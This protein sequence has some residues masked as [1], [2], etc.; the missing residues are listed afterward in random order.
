M[1]DLAQEAPLVLVT[2][3]PWDKRQK[4]AAGSV[5]Q[6]ANF[7]TALHYEKRIARKTGDTFVHV[8]VD[9]KGGALETDFSSQARDH[10]RSRDPGGVRDVAYIGEG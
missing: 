4:R 5:T 2:H 1:I 6:T 8:S 9:S 7:L 3:S 10:R